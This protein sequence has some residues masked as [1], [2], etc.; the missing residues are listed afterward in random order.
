MRWTVLGLALLASPVLGQ[1]VYKWA[2]EQGR[3]HY[4]DRPGRSNA[5]SVGTRAPPAP[6]LDTEAAERRV[7]QRRLLE[8]FVEER[9]EQKER[10]VQTEH[11]EQV[12]VANCAQARDQVRGM[13]TAGRI[14]DLDG[15]G[16]RR[17][18][19]EAARSSALARAREAVNRW[20]Q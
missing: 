9:R 4:G 5:S 6:T 7:Q 13:E 15:Q 3:I 18:L 2:D 11:N 1:A 19:D 8:A 14:Y 10:A 16:N 20:C 17:Y 12:R